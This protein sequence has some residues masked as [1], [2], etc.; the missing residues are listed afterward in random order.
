M[1]HLAL[2]AA[3]A[4][5]AGPTLA[6]TAP[7][8]L[9][10]VVNNT[11]GQEV[12]QVTAVPTPSGVMH[13]TIILHDLP[14]GTHAVHIHETGAC[15]PDFGAA[16]GHLAGDKDHGIMAE[17]G[18]HP[19]D[20]PNIHIPESGALS[21]EYFVTGL[22]ADMLMDADGSAFMIHEGADDYATQPT[23]DAGGRL[24]CGV[25]AAQS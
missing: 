25:F 10:A 19:G 9:H 21:V 5:L 18:P 17:N 16:G 7:E 23:G 6:Q 8:T 4:L 14:R 12:G 2:I 24:G 11:E 15:T 1:R 22:T 20:L 13:L 3:T